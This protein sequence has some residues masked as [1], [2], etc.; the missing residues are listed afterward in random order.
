MNFIKTYLLNLLREDLQG[1]AYVEA[2]KKVATHK[3]WICESLAISFK[4]INDKIDNVNTLALATSEAVAV[5]NE[6]CTWLRDEVDL[7]GGALVTLEQDT[8]S[9]FGFVAEKIDDLAMGLDIAFDLI[10]ELEDEG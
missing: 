8:D 2:S 10:D 6:C 9:A 3:E 5:N 1:I 4:S 7:L